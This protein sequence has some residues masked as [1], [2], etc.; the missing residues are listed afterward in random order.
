MM[1]A[2]LSAMSAAGVMAFGG[3]LAPPGRSADLLKAGAAIQFM[4][5]MATLACATVMQI[6]GLGARR[7]PPFFLASVPLLSGSIYA[8]ALGAPREAWLMAASGALAA[9]VG[10]SILARATLGV[11]DGPQEARNAL[12]RTA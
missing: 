1:L 5:S 7:A 4:H 12:G 11:D 3:L 10:W 6:G 9:A 2:A 8:L